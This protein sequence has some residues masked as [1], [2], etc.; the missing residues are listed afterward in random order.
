MKGSLLPLA[1]VLLVRTVPAASVAE[2][3][4]FFEMRVR[5]V[6]AK[7]CF[8]CHTS[9]RMGGLEMSGRDTILKGG[10]SGPALVPGDPDKSLLMQAVAQTHEKLKMPP[11]G[12]LAAKE[13]DDLRAWI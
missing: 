8:A 11:Q 12:K 7:N 4:D 3:R 2:Q 10:K 1:F 9:S 6:L 5:P 13:I